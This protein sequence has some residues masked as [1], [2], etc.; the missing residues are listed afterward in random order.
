MNNSNQ[1]S[2]PDGRA[3]VGLLCIIGPSGAGKDTAARMLS[4]LTGIPVIVSY[5]TRPMREDEENGREHHFVERCDV[6]SDKMLAYTEYG[7][8]KY[9]TTIDQL[10]EDSIYVIDEVGVDNL[11]K[12]FPDINIVT[13][14]ITANKMVRMRRGVSAERI[15]RDDTRKRLPSTD[16]AIDNSV[17]LT[18]L[19]VQLRA[20]AVT[21]GYKICKP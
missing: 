18:S 4:E 19:K 14:Y 21:E 2:L 13:I 20:I 8:Y 6:P 16:Y 15:S 3:G 12:R 10:S 17:G 1:N 7:G 11:Q 9:W 5:T